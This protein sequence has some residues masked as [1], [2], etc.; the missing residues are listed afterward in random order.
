[1]LWLTAGG[2]V[3][4]VAMIVSLISIILWQ[5]FSTFWPSRLLQLK[6]I[7]GETF[8]GEL[9]QTDRFQLTYS[10]AANLTAEKQAAAYKQLNSAFRSSLVQQVETTAFTQRLPEL[11]KTAQANVLNQISDRKSTRL[12]SSHT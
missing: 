9:T 8:L 3:I 6:T 10:A 5:G 2:L 7:A 12:N 1:M 4:C 11:A